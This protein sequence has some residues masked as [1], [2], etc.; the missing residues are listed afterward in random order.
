MRSRSSD[1][2]ARSQIKNTVAGLNSDRRFTCNRLLHWA[3][4]TRA[5]RH[6]PPGD[7]ACSYRI[8]TGERIASS[9]VSTGAFCLIARPP[10]FTHAHSTAMASLRSVCR[11]PLRQLGRPSC[12]VASNHAR[13]L[14]SQWRGY[15]SAGD[16]QHKVCMTKQ[17]VRNSC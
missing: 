7:S 14:Q 16:A 1:V 10:P 3:R 11:A 15:A 17:V 8:G 6:T 2:G 4:R 13:L 9:V 5:P 12:S